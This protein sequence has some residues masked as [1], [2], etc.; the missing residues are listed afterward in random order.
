M[1]EESL[2]GWRRKD[3]IALFERI[4]MDEFA[5]TRWRHMAETAITGAQRGVG[6]IG[7]DMWQVL[8]DKR[9]RRIARAHERYPENQTRNLNID[10]SALAPGPN[11]PVATQRFEAFREGVQECEARIEI[12]RALGDEALKARL[13]EDLVRRCE[14]YLH[15]RHM[16]MW[17][18]LSSLQTYARPKYPSWFF[19]TKWRQWP[20]VSG[21]NWF[22]SSGW[23][24]RTWQLFSLAGEVAVKLEGK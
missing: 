6:R 8:K 24:E 7:A 15:A 4:R 10:L 13:G 23:Q 16:M 17:L 1:T 19:A 20:S 22:L 18:S 3:L 14:E 12:E 2:H 9:G 11:G 5:S 21:H